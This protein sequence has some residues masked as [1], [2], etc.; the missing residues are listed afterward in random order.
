[1]IR[2]YALLST[3]IVKRPEV[4]LPK[5]RLKTKMLRPKIKKNQKVWYLNPNKQNSGLPAWVSVVKGTRIHLR[6]RDKTSVQVNIEDIYPYSQIYS[7]ERFSGIPT[8]VSPVKWVAFPHYTDYIRAKKYK[9]QAALENETPSSILKDGDR[10][11]ITSD[12]V[13]NSV[14][15][16]ALMFLEPNEK[17]NIGNFINDFDLLVQKYRASPLTE[18]EKNDISLYIADYKTEVL[19]DTLDDGEVEQEVISS[20]ISTSSGLSSKLEKGFKNGIKT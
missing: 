19:D 17:D 14:Y 4:T 3:E 2:N 20:M 9:A 12:E 16:I 13:W 11:F 8:P 6:L 1:M 18:N 15:S 7:D 5:A 10:R